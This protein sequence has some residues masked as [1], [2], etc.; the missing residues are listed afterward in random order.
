MGLMQCNLSISWRTQL[1]SGLFYGVLIV[2]VLLIPWSGHDWPI[3]LSLV[4]L[5]TLEALLSQK[6]I[7]KTK[8]PL[9]L[10]DKQ[11]IYWD[12]QEWQITRSPLILSFGVLLSLKSN[13]TGRSYRLWIAGDS[14]SK[15]Q[16]RGL[17]YE[18]LRQEP[19]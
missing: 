15:E 10:L 6:R 14:L 5:M 17:R 4:F 9:T 12:E 11:S 16:W 13:R 8:G 2:I 7:S 1:M 18:L 19:R 3:W